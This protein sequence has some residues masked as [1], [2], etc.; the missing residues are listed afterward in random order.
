MASKVEHIHQKRKMRFC[1]KRLP[2]FPL[3][4]THLLWINHRDRGLT[5]VLNHL[6]RE[7]D[8]TEFHNRLRRGCNGTQGT[9][10]G[11]QMQ[12]AGRE[13]KEDLCS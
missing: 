2:S 3:A 12:G 13:A 9:R 1:P 4:P 8:N 11:F 6:W 5:A 10:R 7:L